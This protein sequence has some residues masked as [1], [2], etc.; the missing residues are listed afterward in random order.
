[1]GSP[2]G[3]M[4]DAFL[5]LLTDRRSPRKAAIRQPGVLLDAATGARIIPVRLRTAAV[6]VL[7]AFVGCGEDRPDGPPRPGGTFQLDCRVRFALI[8]G[9]MATMQAT[10]VHDRDAGH[11]ARPAMQVD[12]TRLTT[13]AA[14]HGVNQCTGPNGRCLRSNR[15]ELYLTAQSV[16]SVAAPL[17]LLECRF[18]SG[19][20]VTPEDFEIRDVFATD[21]L[22]G[23]VEPPPGIAITAVDCSGPMATTTTLP[24]EPDCG[25]VACSEAEACVDGTCVAT[26]RYAIEFQTDTRAMYAALGVD[27]DFSCRDGGFV[28]YEDKVACK[29]LPSI[30]AFSAFHEAPCSGDGRARL[31][32]GL[33][34]L[35]GWPGPQPFMVCEYESSTGS[36]PRAES[37][38]PAVND[39]IDLTDRPIK[40]ATVSV[41]SIRP[42]AP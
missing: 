21:E 37:F 27:I 34:S 11:F 24:D 14:V 2:P 19:Y 36:P 26:D 6:L 25:D 13:L 41:A 3:G 30:N 17:D 23:D 40:N 35:S 33:I 18:L 29:P 12:C 42:I 8:S 31:S 22:L 9:E 7:L 39:A 1:M 32:A 15:P 4:L 16:Q 10:V 28:G 20:V 38:R 5:Q